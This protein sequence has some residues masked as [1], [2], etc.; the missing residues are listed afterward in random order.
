MIYKSILL[1]KILEINKNI[2]KKEIL[3]IINN[4]IKF[5]KNILKKNKKIKIKNFGYFKSYSK[6]KIIKK[7][8]L[9]Y[10]YKKINI[11]YFK[12]SKYIILKLN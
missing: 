8:F 2:S 5:I 3:L 4:L 10:K 12:C 6:F 7:N 11:I 1:N 9:I